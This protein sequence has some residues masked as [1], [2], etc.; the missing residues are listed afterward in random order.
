MSE[1]GADRPRNLHEQV[2]RLVRT[3]RELFLSQRAMEAQLRRVRLLNGY[4]LATGA[5]SSSA[6]ILRLA[7]V[8]FTELFSFEQGLA[9]LEAQ[10][11]L[12]P[13]ACHAVSGLEERSGERLAQLEPLPVEVAQGLRGPWFAG[14]SGSNP[15]TERAGALLEQLEELFQPG[16]PTPGF[17]LVLP[18]RQ[19]PGTLEGALLLRRLSRVVPVEQPMPTEADRD[20]L[21]VTGQQISAAVANARLVGDL[22]ESYAQLA[23][24]QA[25]LVQKERL[26]A[27]GELAA[28]IAHEVRNPLGAIF[29]SLSR[30]RKLTEQAEAGQL[31]DIMDE[32]AQRLDRMVE[33]LLDF[34][35]PNAPRLRP[36]NLG[37]I[38]RSAL[39][40]ARRAARLDGVE[41]TLDVDEDLPLLQLD[42]RMIRQALLNLLVN[43]A[44]AMAGGGRLAVRAVLERSE[45][46]LLARVDVSDTGSGVAGEAADRLFEPFFTT[47][48]TGTGLGLAVVRRF[49]EA[50][51]GRASFRSAPGQGSTFSLRLPVEVAAP[52]SESPTQGSS[53]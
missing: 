2:K 13:V 25:G 41:I 4:A 12:R 19:R 52:E 45:G 30:L 14:R 31:L 34:A 24:A 43:A 3:E 32:E 27:V 6:E 16:S 38:V 33:D 53:V 50:H 29:N 9:V 37:A 11:R 35:R 51:R 46:R 10:G 23:A 18:L 20:F 49:V 22:R 8:L 42:A 1:G 47:K 17:S 5:A 7:L 26:A 21:E 39:E 48:A 28:Q 44:Q 40:G 36:E 15:G